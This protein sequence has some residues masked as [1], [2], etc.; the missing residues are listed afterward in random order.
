MSHKQKYPLFLIPLLAIFVISAFIFD[1][2][3]YN[4]VIKISGIKPIALPIHISTPKPKATLI[5]TPS[6]SP[7]PSPTPRPLTFEEMNQLYGPCTYLPVIFYHHIQD[8][9]QADAQGHKSLTVDPGIFASQ[10]Q[11]LKDKGYNFATLDQINSFFDSGA[12]VPAHSV[13]VSFDDGYNDFEDN[14]M[15]VIRN[16]GI[17]VTMFLPPGLVGNPGY[18]NWGEV[19]SEK[20]SGLVYF[21]NHTWSHASLA[22]SSDTISR[23]VDT[24]QTLLA[25]HGLNPG[26]YLAYPYGTTSDLAISLLS[27]KGYKLAFTTVPGG[28]LCKAQRLYLPRI[29]IGNAPLSAYGF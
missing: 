21:A 13:L 19:D 14:A 8:L 18:L 27:Q 20:G 12:G 29:R 10:M 5:P 3:L 7:S 22:A 26:M 24:A 25:Q 15:P 2:L 28:T 4:N 9:A 17:H 16:L 11:Y 23:E 6:P 1:F